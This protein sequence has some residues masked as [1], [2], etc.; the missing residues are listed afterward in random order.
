MITS[1]TNIGFDELEGANAQFPS[2]TFL[3][4]VFGHRTVGELK[5]IYSDLE[6]KDEETANLINALFPKKVSDVWPV[7]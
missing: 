3:H 5:N 2:F 6:T 7:S 4:L 1:I